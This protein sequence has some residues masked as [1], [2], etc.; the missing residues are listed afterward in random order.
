MMQPLHH[1]GYWAADLD[2]AVKRWERDL[3]VGPFQIIEHV[4]FETFVLSIDGQ[5]HDN[6][7]F[8]HTAAF[9]AWG[10]IV[11][12]LGQVHA[13][14]HR[15]AAAYGIADGALSHVSWV[16][17][18]LEQESAPRTTRLP[19]DQH[20][21]VRPDLGGLARRRAAV[22]APGRAAPAQRRHRRDA[23]PPGRAARDRQDGMNPLRSVPIPGY[24]GTVRNITP[25]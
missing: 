16:V 17:P 22:P 10:P 13:I 9:A 19:P 24:G 1:I 4:P 21:P 7:L 11:V 12:E 25:A 8:D 23:R 20:G 15:L 3:G 18:D 2:A 5:P 14:D 6:V